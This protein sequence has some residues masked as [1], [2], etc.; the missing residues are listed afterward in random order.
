MM[1]NF[2]A[3]YWRALMLPLIATGGGEAA[4]SAQS[5]PAPTQ[6]PAPVL[7]PGLDNFSLT[8]RPGSTISRPA[9]PP[10][11]V[12]T[13]P[14]PS[15]TTRPAP[16]RL[17]PVPPPRAV[18]TPAARLAG[19]SPVPTAAATP[20]PAPTEAPL[21]VA[22]S[23]SPPVPE[24]SATVAPEP[25]AAPVARAPFWPM[26][27]GAAA[28]AALL[29]GG[30]FF[31][32][33]RRLGQDG[34]YDEPITEPEGHARFDLIADVPSPASES[35]SEA[36][37]TPPPAAPFRTPLD[38]IAPPKRGAHAIF[39]LGGVA[40]E[41]D[42]VAAEPDTETDVAPEPTPAR[43]GADEQ[44]TAAVEPEVAPIA[45]TG[46]PAMLDVELRAKRAGTN[47]LSAAVDYEIVVRN[48]GGG[49]ARA[50]QADVR[51]LSAGAEQDGWIRSLFSTPIERPI[52][53]PFDLPP[54]SAITLSGMAM[55]PKEMLSVMTVQGRVLFVPVL[56]INL[57]Y[58]RGGD[59]GQTAA[60]FVVGIDRGEGVK[61][62]PFR[63]DSGPRMQAD[64][65]TLPY[66]VAVRR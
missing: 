4:V 49:P 46:A 42:A 16:A 57:L 27:G 35:A 2:A 63:L 36:A 25:A 38:P 60:S 12:T 48:S 11:V 13:L 44:V 19:P 62:A 64:V 54:D 28:L 52:T 30:L 59:T 34:G 9:A 43:G 15:P 66:T 45:P 39:D 33:R 5:T 10:P 65:T 29:I 56:A 21:A 53:P 8:P 14:T 20:V 40:A 1:S 6:T 51:L 3:R 50:V 41:P 47:L 17:S 22:P 58:D 18:A 24:E 23:L 31:L 26:L 55:M 37:D 7:I 61:M 32:R